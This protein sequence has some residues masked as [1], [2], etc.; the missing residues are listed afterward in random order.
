ME[1][2]VLTQLCLF[3]LIFL[4]GCSMDR[5]GCDYKTHFRGPDCSPCIRSRC[6]DLCDRCVVKGPMCAA[7]LAC[8]NDEGCGTK[9]IP[10]TCI[11]RCPT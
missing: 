7:C 3:V 4:T 5:I 6:D 9:E 8:L 2:K 10:N 1:R 11:R